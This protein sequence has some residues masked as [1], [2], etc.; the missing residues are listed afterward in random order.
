MTDSSLFMPGVDEAY[1]RSRDRLR[2]AE[3]ALRD[4][5]EE[6]AA[7]R[8]SLPPGPVVPDYE[9]IED[10]NRVRLSD[11]FAEN[12][13]YL[14]LYHLMYWAD[15]DSFC[16]MCSL[17]IDGFNGI[18]PHVTQRANFVIAS[19]APVD[20]LQAWGAHREWHRLRLLSGDGPA[21]A[22]AIDAEDAD[23]NPDS[24]IVVFAKDGHEVRHVYTAHPMLEDRERGIDL[25]S[26]VWH[27][28]DLMPSGRDDWSGSN[29]GFDAAMQAV[30][31]ERSAR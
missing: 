31:R 23:G 7:M 18:A 14:I 10:G 12:K 4:R 19:R 15:D 22:R 29:E 1:R 3:I 8:R 30:V 26:P 11:L 27:L 16:P 13:P 2:S 17:W 5:I 21:F 20:K 25:L 9:F 28:F 6:V 24:T